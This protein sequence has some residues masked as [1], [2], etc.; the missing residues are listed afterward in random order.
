MSINK[1]TRSR[2][3]FS[4]TT[5]TMMPEG[6]EVRTLVDQLQPAIG[7]R[8]TN[9]QFLS[10][11]YVNHSHPRGYE[12]FQKTMSKYREDED[13]DDTEI[14]VDVVKEWNAKGKFIWMILDDGA[15]LSTA[16]GVTS[17]PTTSEERDDDYLRS[18]W[19]TLGMSGR[20]IN[21]SRTDYNHDKA[22]WYMEF[23]D[24]SS[25]TIDELSPPKRR[26]IYYHDTR[27]FGKA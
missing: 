23:I 2:S 3:S 7:K 25:T 13:N 8:L 5:P 1:S 18:I 10:G 9:L 6:P 27:N 21:D 4:R 24:P 11:R 22:R 19:I 15:S 14:I 26:K 20:F 16:A 12:E 17:S